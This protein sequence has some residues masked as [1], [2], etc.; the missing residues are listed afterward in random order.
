M[1]IDQWRPKGVE[2]LESA[3]WGA[4]ECSGNVC[5]VAGPGAGKTEFLAQKVAY[6]FENNLCKESRRVLAISFKKDAADNLKAR[7]RERCAKKHSSRFDSMTFDAF[8][9]S[10]VDRFRLSLPESLRPKQ[11]YDIVNFSEYQYRGFLADMRNR[12]PAQSIQIEAIQT[13]N[14]QHVLLARHKLSD[15][16]AT[17]LN[18]FLCQNWIVTKLG[19][20]VDFL[21]IN[22][23]ADYLLRNSVHL[24]KALALTYA[25]VV[26]DEFQ[27]TTFAQY[28]FLSTLLEVI[29]AKV[30]VVGDTK[31]RIMSWAGAKPDSFEDF[32]KAF[33]A[34]TFELQMNYRSSPELVQIHHVLA[35]S[36]DEDYT[37][38]MSAVPAKIDGGVA[39]IWNFENPATEFGFLADWINSDMNERGLLPSDYALLVRQKPDDTHAALSEAFLERG[40]LVCNEAQRFGKLSLQDI[41]SDD[42]F[43]FLISLLR[44]SIENRSATAWAYVSQCMEFF[45]PVDCAEVRPRV[46]NLLD[47]LIQR[48][49]R[50]NF[51]SFATPAKSIAASL[52]SIFSMVGANTVRG[53][54]PQYYSQVNFEMFTE[55]VTEYLVNCAAESS[56]WIDFIDQ[57]YRI[58]QIPL[59][60]VHKSKGLEYDTVLFLGLDDS[61]W[62]SYSEANSEGKSTF[63]VGLSRA[64]QRVVFTYAARGRERVSELYELLREAGVQERVIG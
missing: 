15:S 5:V 28:D 34:E 54:F 32:S 48:H 20:N 35:R 7:V 41:V 8:T 12:N 2:D 56:G 19:G 47:T 45:F 11:D 64:K 14:F 49:L 3:A 26:V 25:F 44:V 1:T 59:L 40:L 37:P 62:W 55:A 61:A 50:P 17:T 33:D 16:M 46:R 13:R 51:S 36:I 58:G 18:S 30:A 24:S 22:R 42:L 52:D 31:Q 57:V 60:T 39:E 4:L 23:L 38:V 29:G 43:H 63:F 27:D 9:K 10:L 21:I 6:L 53:A